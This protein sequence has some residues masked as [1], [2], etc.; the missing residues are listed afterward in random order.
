MLQEAGV[1]QA[2]IDCLLVTSTEGSIACQIYQADLAKLGIKMNI[3]VMETAA[4]LDQV[5]N[6]RYTGIYWSGASYGQLAPGSTFGGTKAWDPY[7]NNQGFQSDQYAQL[8]AAAGTEVDP[9]RQKQIY[10]QLNDLILDESFAFVVS[11]SSQI[12]M[13]TARV[14]GL[15]PTYHASFDFT[16]AWIES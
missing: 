5:N 13:T 12:M 11:S 3:K 4:W 10:S 16:E 2:E 8:V 9:P 1:T 6:R 14:H 15:H 7:N